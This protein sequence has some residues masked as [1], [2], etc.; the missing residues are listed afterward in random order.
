MPPSG[1]N[2]RMPWRLIPALLLAMLVAPATAS[3]EIEVGVGRAD[4][5]PPTGYYMMGW[6]RSDA[7][8][9]GQHT[10]LWARAI[11]LRQGNKKIALV[12]EDMNG[13]P[14]GM[15]AQAAGMNKDIGFSEQNVLDSASHTHAAPTSYYNFTTY[16]SVFMTQRSPTDFD[17]S[18]TRDPQ[19]YTFMVKQLAQ[20]IRRANA[21]LGPGAVGWGATTIE[22]LTANRSLEAHLANHGIQLDYGKGSPSDDPDGP[23]HTIDPAVNV[24][25]VDKYIRGKRTPV[26]MWSTFS[27]HGTVNKFQFNVFNEDHHGA[28]THKVE[29]AIRRDGKVPAGQDVVNAYGNTDEGDISAGLTR[30]GPAAAD[31]VGTAEADAFLK[32]WRAAG[33]KM[34]RSPALE[35]RWTRMCFCGQNTAAG[36]VADH[37]AFGL[38]EFTGSE[39]GRGPLFDIT[40]TP[41]E[42]DHLPIGAGGNLPVPST[43]AADPAQGDKIVIGAPLDVPKA[44]PLLAVR[45]GNRMIVS[46]PGEMTA[47]MGRRVR[48]AVLDASSGAGI[49][50][51]VISGLA[52]EYADYFTTP[53]EYDTQHYEGGAT[54]YGRA[55][56]VALQEGLVALAGT[57][58]SGKPAPDPYPFDPTNGAKPDGQPFPAGADNAKISQQPDPTAERLSHPTVKWQ[59]G[60]R[61]YDRPLDRAFVTVQRQVTLKVRATPKKPRRRPHRRHGRGHREPRFTGKL[62]AARTVKRW[63]AVDSDLGLNILWSVDDSGVYSAHWEV[64]LNA[65]TGRYRFVV[66]ANRYGLTSGSFKATGSRALSAAPVNAGPGRVG[67]ELDYPQPNFREAVGDPPGDLTADLTSR[68]ETA[69]SGLATFLV[70][71][72]RVTVSE[73]E[74]G[75]FTVAA[76]PGAKVEVAKG[77]VRD[78]HGNANGNELTLTGT[79]ARQATSE[80]EDDPSIIDGSAQ[81]RLDNARRTWRKHGPASYGYRV[82]LSCFCTAESTRPRDFVV[83]HRRPV[84]PPKG[85]KHVATMSRLFKQVQEA[86]DDRADH[87]TV[88][89]RRNGSL[90]LL[91]VDPEE[92]TFDEEYQY[93]VS[94]FRKLR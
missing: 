29:A 48:K 42:G 90:K 87:L 91:S 58:A 83:R 3:A 49:T 53:E 56:S 61:G 63:M 37:G 30:S 7:K 72:K 75:V 44:V 4:I 80:G 92:M 27:D 2:Q 39:E 55:S 22:D 82:Q 43:P 10:R 17:L 60:Q 21:N 20:A 74:N 38:S 24:L 88:K 57:L 62:R 77:A 81:R 94:R 89:Y 54:I 78:T 65:R 93:T 9:V 69:T 13:I 47:E 19:L 67:V 14:G 41:F 35:S 34:Q 33:K 46:V 84:H 5:T 79:A 71:G 18:G 86:I 6:V 16:N 23:L 15:L 25:R 45:I 85:W 70:D 1:E 11:V 26:G 76:P 32:A 59:G 12:T 51:T 73:N 50:T 36:A 31:F 8:L 52:N 40:R 66:R 64:P 28:A 68:P